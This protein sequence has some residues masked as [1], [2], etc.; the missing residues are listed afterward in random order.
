M[1]ITAFLEAGKKLAPDDW[2]HSGAGVIRSTGSQRCVAKAYDRHFEHAEFIAA[3]RNAAK[4]IEELRD[5]ARVVVASEEMRDALGI[6]KAFTPEV[7]E[8]IREIA[9]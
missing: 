9:K 3:A 2:L 6:E 7:V 5:F 8:R 4:E 1:T